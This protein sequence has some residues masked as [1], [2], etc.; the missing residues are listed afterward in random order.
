MGYLDQIKTMYGYL[1]E[2]TEENQEQPQ[3]TTCSSRDSNRAAL[4]KKSSVIT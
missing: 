4:D 1:L 3:T 2:G